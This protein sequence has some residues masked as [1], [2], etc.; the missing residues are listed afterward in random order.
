MKPNITIFGGATPLPGEP[1]YEQAYRLGSLLGAAGYTVLTG[2]Y[3]GTMEAVSRGAAE[4]GAHVI[5]ITCTLLEQRRPQ[6][7]NP[8]VREEIRHH[9]L[10]ARMY[11]LID[12]CHA[13]LAL[14]GGIG[15]LAEIAAMWSAL[16]TDRA[17]PRP[18]IL[19]GAG[20]QTTF[21]AMLA[22]LGGYVKPH[23]RTLLQFAPDETAA[24]ALLQASLPA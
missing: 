2:G 7:A 10:R 8:W 13:A 9:T 15:T 1:A 4:T 19:I 18:L 16:Q 12:R 22:E 6:G 3:G 14:P 17:Q 24:A 20:W 23:D 11:D 5:G 21:N